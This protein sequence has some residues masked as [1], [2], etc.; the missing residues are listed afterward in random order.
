MPDAGHLSEASLPHTTPAPAPYY[1]APPWDLPNA[2]LIKVVYETDV[3]AVLEWL[4]P[5]LT[6]SS[7]PYAII[8]V[9]RYAD[10]PVGAFNAATQYIGC[11]A[12]FFTRALA[13]QTVVD[14]PVALAGLREIWGF[15]AQP[16]E[17]QIEEQSDGV[18]VLVATQAGNLL[19]L[20]L[21]GAENIAPGLARFDPVLTLRTAP[22]L[23]EEARHD[24]LQMVQVDPEYEVT[25]AQRGRAEIELSGAWAVLPMRGV[26]AGT[27]CE[28]NTELPLA[29]FVMP[30]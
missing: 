20:E 19:R 6:R 25:S 30:Y 11:R 4:P 26:V 18:V 12:G 29:R 22:S 7:P 24:L 27:A 14:S 1:P 23:T 2:Q 10:S 28:M 21:R 8:T 3:E 9:E 16:G 5:K 17:V 15:P 13:L